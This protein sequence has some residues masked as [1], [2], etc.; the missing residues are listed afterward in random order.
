M[1]RTTVRQ[2]HCLT[3][4]WTLSM[5]QPTHSLNCVTVSSLSVAN[6]PL[7]T[8]LGRIL[9]T[10]ETATAYVTGNKNVSPV[11]Q[12]GPLICCNHFLT[13]RG[14]EAQAWLWIHG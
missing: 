11:Q 1:A 14:T 10:K 9:T 5:K 4:G 13:T 8:G 2:I 6:S 12:C 7:R 3:V